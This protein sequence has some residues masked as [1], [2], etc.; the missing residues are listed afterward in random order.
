MNP[1]LENLRVF[2][3]TL[4]IPV[5]ILFKLCVRPFE[6]PRVLTKKETIEILARRLSSEPDWGERDQFVCCPIADPELEKIRLDL[7]DVDESFPSK[8]GPIFLAIEGR[9]KIQSWLGVI[10]HG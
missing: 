2:L 3:F 8:D 6:K 9:A 7:I 4:L 1:L 5:M 10:K